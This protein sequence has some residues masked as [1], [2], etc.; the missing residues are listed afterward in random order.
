MT[1]GD[2]YE[3]GR[4]LYNEKDFKNALAWMNEA[5]R[6]Y[7]SGKEPYPFTEVDILEYIGFSHYLM[8]MYTYVGV[9]I[10]LLDKNN[11]AYLH[12]RFVSKSFDKAR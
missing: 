3:L 6:K 9:E 7:K 11:L 10:M 2:C 4:A 8:G 5:L 12:F 1:A